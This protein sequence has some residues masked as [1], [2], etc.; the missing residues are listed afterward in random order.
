VL[1]WGNN[2]KIEKFGKE[3]ARELRKEQK[4]MDAQWGPRE[5]EQLDR[6]F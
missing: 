5:Q 1:K 4:C 3:K 2:R 6:E